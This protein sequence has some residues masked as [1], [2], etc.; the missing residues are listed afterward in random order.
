MVRQDFDGEGQEFSSEE[1]E[2]GHELSDDS[3]PEQEQEQE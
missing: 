3:E 2:S 1:E